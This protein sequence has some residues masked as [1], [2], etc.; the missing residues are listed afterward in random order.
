MDISQVALSPFGASLSSMIA[1][2]RLSHSETVIL[3]LE[4]LESILAP[5]AEPTICNGRTLTLA[6]V[7][8]ISR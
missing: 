2:S 4:A 1:D 3:Q 7:A 5:G 6:H 8:A